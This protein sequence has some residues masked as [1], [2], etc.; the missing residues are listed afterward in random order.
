MMWPFHSLQK[1]LP[2]EITVAMDGRLRQVDHGR[3]EALLPSPAVQRQEG[4]IAIPK[5]GRPSHVEE[6]VGA[7]DIDLS[8]GDLA[9]LEHAFPP[10][11]GPM[12]LE[13]L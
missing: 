2:N 4:V 7:L 9:A 5:A 3:W 10:P 12:P 11:S 6:N 13:I 8:K 1:P